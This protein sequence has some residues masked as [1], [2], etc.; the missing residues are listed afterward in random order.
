M[1][2]R[3]RRLIKTELKQKTEAK[4]ASVFFYQKKAADY[5]GVAQ[6]KL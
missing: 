5:A 3:R 2:Y 6:K 4:N 1:A